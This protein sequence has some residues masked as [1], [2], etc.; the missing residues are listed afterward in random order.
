[1]ARRTLLALAL[2]GLVLA[3]SLTV[4][5][6]TGQ[7]GQYVLGVYV[8][9]GLV[10]VQVGLCQAPTTLD[11]L[12]LV[13]LPFGIAQVCYLTAP[14]PTDLTITVEDD[15]MGPVGFRWIG[16]TSPNPPKEP[17]PLPCGADGDSATGSVHLSLR[18]ECTHILVRPALGSIMGTV[19]LS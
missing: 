17:N 12:G 5:S 11:P 6:H 16:F 13:G 3:P 14:D 18:A 7:S 19:T 10:S 8:R 9:V 2:A 1:M 15:V 4:A